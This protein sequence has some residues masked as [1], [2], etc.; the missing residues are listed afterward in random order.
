[1]LRLTVSLSLSL[2]LFACSSANMNDSSKLGSK[3]PGGANA[4]PEA[5][6]S[7]LPNTPAGT[8]P[9]VNNNP[10]V[11]GTGTVYDGSIGGEGGS[12]DPILGATPVIPPTIIAGASLSCS[13]TSANKELRCETKKNGALIDV[14]P[15]ASY[16]AAGNGVKV[17][18]QTLE[19]EMKEIGVYVAPAP[20]FSSQFIV[21]MRLSAT[22]YLT[23]LVG[24]G[25]LPFY[26]HIKD[27]SF[28]ENFAFN[29]TQRDFLAS[30]VPAAKWRAVPNASSS[31][32]ADDPSFIRIQVN[33]AGT[34]SPHPSVD[35]WKWAS[36]VSRC[37]AELG[38]AGSNYSLQ[39]AMPN[40]TVGNLY[41][42]TFL[43]R[44]D[45][46][47]TAT[48]PDAMVSAQWGLAEDTKS[49][50]VTP[51]VEWKRYS[52]NVWAKSQSVTLNFE[53]KGAASDKGTLIDAVHVLDMGIPPTMP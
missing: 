6:E 21:S 53:E 40:L 4:N 38:M 33:A 34:V 43:A 12:L 48:P 49:I 44:A 52:M 7:G 24:T 39:Q 36:L 19:M 11:S 37:A 31:C 3:K 26:D 2:G 50:T 14:K 46:A 25:A 47:N 16:A 23:D 20:S 10:P 27:P 30:E 22:S 32:P 28:E 41:Y 35:G 29:G 17:V 45:D 1:M 13:L 8:P 18:W 42:V 51:G 5:P 15:Q 9:T